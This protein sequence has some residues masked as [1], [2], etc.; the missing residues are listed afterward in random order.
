MHM[1]GP[2]ALL[3]FATRKIPAAGVGEIGGGRFQL[4]QSQYYKGLALIVNNGPC[5]DYYY[6]LQNLGFKLPGMMPSHQVAI[7]SRLDLKR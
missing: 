5:A 4:K 7:L 1:T 2:L 3:T 6:L